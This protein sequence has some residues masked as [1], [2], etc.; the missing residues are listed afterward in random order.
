MQAQGNVACFRRFD[1]ARKFNFQL[2]SRTATRPICNQPANY[3]PS[4]LPSSRKLIIIF[5]PIFGRMALSLNLS[6]FYISFPT[7]RVRLRI[8][9]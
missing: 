7:P 1:F 8:I 3:G 9:L 5:L 6:N 2:A 4:R